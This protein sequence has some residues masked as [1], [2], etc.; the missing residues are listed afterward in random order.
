V[1]LFL[2]LVSCVK[3]YLFGRQLPKIFSRLRCNSSCYLRYCASTWDGTFRAADCWRPSVLCHSACS[4]RRQLSAPVRLEHPRRYSTVHKTQ[5][6][7]YKFGELRLTVGS[8]CDVTVLSLD[9]NVYLDQNVVI[10]DDVASRLSLDYQNSEDGVSHVSLSESKDVENA[11]KQSDYHSD[12]CSIEVPIKYGSCYI[13]LANKTFS[14]L[15]VKIH[16]GQ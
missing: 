5:R 7:V 12:V 11:D 2:L 4:S 1:W 14:L 16:I 3:M 6:E 8:R 9:P 13:L 15:L 10:V